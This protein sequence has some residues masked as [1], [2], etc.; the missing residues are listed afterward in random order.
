MREREEAKETKT[1]RHDL[2]KG[3]EKERESRRSTRVEGGRDMGSPARP[4]H[5][6]VL[7]SVSRSSCSSSSST[8]Q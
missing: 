3:G 1:C 8:E 5:V 4:L 2:V 7:G 6:L